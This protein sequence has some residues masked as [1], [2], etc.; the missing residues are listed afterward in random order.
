V[1]HRQHQR[2][3]AGAQSAQHL[4]PGH[5]GELDIEQHQV[6]RARGDAREGVAR[7]VGL[8]D[9]ESGRAQHSREQRTRVDVAVD[10]QNMSLDRAH[11][12][13]W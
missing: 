8:L 9:G 1:H 5:V 2:R 4:A 11:G 12:G 3:R 7:R 10:Y 6:G 13:P